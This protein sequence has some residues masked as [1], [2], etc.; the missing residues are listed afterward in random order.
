MKNKLTKTALTKFSEN[1]LRTLGKEDLLFT[2]YGNVMAR[3]DAYA[4]LAELISEYLN[5]EDK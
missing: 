4:R 2:H 1:S 3:P 5:E